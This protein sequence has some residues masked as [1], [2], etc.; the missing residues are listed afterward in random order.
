MR[1]KTSD[2]LE[3]LLENVRRPL[4]DTIRLRNKDTRLL[5]EEGGMIKAPFIQEAFAP[6][7]R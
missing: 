3:P 7:T 4:L 5:V 2:L 1:R 6:L